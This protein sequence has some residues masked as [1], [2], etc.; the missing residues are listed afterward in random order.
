VWGGSGSA[1]VTR[2]Y[3]PVSDS[4]WRT[5]S[6]VVT[7]PAG[8]TSLRVLLEAFPNEQRPVQGIV[9]YTGVRISG[10]QVVDTPPVAM[11]P[12]YAVVPVPAGAHTLSVSDPAVKVENLIPNPSFEQGLWQKSVGDCNAFDANPSLNMRLDTRE[13]SKGGQSLELL[14]KRHIA[15]TGPPGQIEVAEG[16]TYQ[17]R[18]DYQSPNA[19][20]AHYSVSFND[21]NHTRVTPED[22]PITTRCEIL[23]PAPRSLPLC[24]GAPRKSILLW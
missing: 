5:L 11:A 4:S 8:A 17:L 12:N 24:L 6:R 16:H 22:L 15:C 7:V 20:A 9:H 19:S 2:Q 1:S 23:C 18:F 13:K 21:P 3:V 10:L 14:A